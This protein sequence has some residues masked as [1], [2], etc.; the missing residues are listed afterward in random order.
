MR[1]FS[2]LVAVMYSA[3]CWEHSED[4]CNAAF[5]YPPSLMSLLRDEAFHVLKNST[6]KLFPHM[7]TCGGFILIFGKT[8]T[9]M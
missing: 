9:V 8:N 6:L 2:K 3:E 5:A 4:Q 1:H 7:Y